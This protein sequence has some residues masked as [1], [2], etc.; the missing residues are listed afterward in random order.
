MVFNDRYLADRFIDPVFNASIED[1]TLKELISITR[2]F[3]REKVLPK[4]EEMEKK[5]QIDDDLVE[6]MRRLEIFGYSIPAE[7]GGQGLGIIGDCL[8]IFEIAYGDMSTSLVPLVTNSLF[9]KA[10][11]IGGNKKQK[12]DILPKVVAGELLGCYA[13]TDPGGSSFSRDMETNLKKKGD[14]YILKGNKRFISEADKADLAVVFARLEDYDDKFVGILVP[15]KHSDKTQGFYNIKKGYEVIKKE[16]KPGIHASATCEIVMEDMEIPP[17]NILGYDFDGEKGYA[18]AMQTLGYSRPTIA[19]QALGNAKHSLSCLMTY[20][21]EIVR[22]R[23]KYLIDIPEFRESTVIL[24]GKLSE[25]ISYLL[26]IAKAITKGDIAA[27]KIL[28]IHSS[29][30][31]KLGTDTGELVCKE[32][33]CMVGGYGYT[34]DYPFSRLWRDSLVPRIY[35]GH[36]DVQVYQAG[37]TLGKILEELREK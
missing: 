33:L 35:E 16:N 20:A 5:K 11:M 7:Y 2:R 23:G 10:V 13:L 4:A 25:S 3:S 8:S 15:N 31:K 29:M 24:S 1:D 19:A 12:E 17:E 18:I 37:K 26:N 36:N 34:E 21:T 14:M 22:G 27:D 30:L 6:E 9:A 32:C 28:R